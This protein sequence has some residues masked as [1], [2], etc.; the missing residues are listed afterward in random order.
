M[1]SAVR[2]CQGSSSS[3]AP[4]FCGGEEIAQPGLQQALFA[5]QFSG[6]NGVRDLHFRPSFSS[7]R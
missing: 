2:L 5:P 4:A 6:E 1:C 3:A 7:S